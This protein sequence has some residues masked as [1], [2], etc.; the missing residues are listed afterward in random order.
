MIMKFLNYLRYTLLALIISFLSLGCNSFLD[1]LPDDM[2]T[3]EMVFQDRKRTEEWLASTYA[4]NL[5]PLNGLLVANGYPYLTDDAQLAFPMGQYW[6]WSW[7]VGYLQGSW[8]PTI[9]API[10]YWYDAFKLARRAYQF[11]E[12]VRPLPNQGLTE[13]DVLQMKNEAR[14]QVA[15][16]YVRILEHYGPFPLMKELVPS[17]I[18]PSELSIPR[19]PYDEIVDYLDAEL[20]DLAAYFPK[21]YTDDSDVGRPTKGAVLAVRARMLLFAAS[22][23]FNGNP[24]YADLANP[25]GQL[26]FNPTYKPE[27]WARAAEAYRDVLA[28]ADEGVY[29]LYKEYY[30]GQIDPF[31]SLQ[32]LFLTHKG[33]KEIILS[34]P[35]VDYGNYNAAC[36]PRGLVGYAGY[37]GATQNI[38]DAFF[39]KNGLPIADANSGYK[40]EGFTDQPIFYDHTAY[41]M[42]D[43][44]ETT[45]LVVNTN[46][47]NMYANREPRF[48]VFIRHN[49]Q[50]IPQAGRNT[51]F[52]YGEQDGGP[53]HD[54]P[55]CGYLVRKAVQPYADPR[56]GRVSYQPG[57]LI[58]LGEVYLNY[59]EALNEV[60]PNHPDILK[61]VNL[62]RERAGI[63]PLDTSMLGDKE[64]LRE[65]IRRERRVEFALEGDIRFH[66]LRRWKLAEEVF[67][68]PIYGL[69]NLATTDEE[70]YKRK[71]FMNRVFHKKMYL[72]PIPQHYV[73]NNVNLVQNKFW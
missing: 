22:P 44:D 10:D 33:N 46:T 56:G 29:D 12:Q 30:N 39:M 14:F 8:N 20:N 66:D 47:F 69:N 26:L 40:E 45:G 41:N 23:L 67:A 6:P 42:A 65:A 16:M 3:E 5:D 19:T 49:N 51:Q 64:K 36:L 59:A 70:F 53:T 71:P 57:I 25:D 72:W 31:M 11:I 27:K 50:W 38:V 43:P 37:Y 63:P 17:N 7:I 21:Q 60:D 52:K 2:L 58:R 34:R 62:I 55:Q 54:S 4:W 73:D 13:A 24:D 1:K 68:E 35:S 48:Y 9:N 18:T 32:N 61:Y 28:L 15:N